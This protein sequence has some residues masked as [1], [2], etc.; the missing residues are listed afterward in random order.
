MD[1]LLVVDMQKALFK[2][3]RFNAQIVVSNINLIGAAI[4]RRGGHVI[5]VQHNG[6][7]A[8]G[9]FP[10]SDGWFLLDALTVKAT[11][12]VIEKSICDS[13]FATNLSELLLQLAPERV[14]VAG[15]ASEF[16][17][18]TTI[19]SAVSRGYS[20]VAVADGHTTADRPH[21]KAELIVKHHNWVWENLIA[22]K[23]P[24]CVKSAAEIVAEINRPIN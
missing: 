24:V 16:C 8:E 6:T 17:V 4:R 22:P 7:A 10:H 23:T 12:S 15:C 14:I 11:D 9:L 21:L 19:R 13:F 20:V 1:V 5:Y 18:D 3:P 2:T